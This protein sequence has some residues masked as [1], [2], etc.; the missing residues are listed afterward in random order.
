MLRS[1]PQIDCYSN[2]FCAVDDRG[3]YKDHPLYMEILN[4]STIGTFNVPVVHCTYLINSKYIDKLDY[5]DGSNDYEFVIFSRSA[6]KNNIGQFICNEEKF[7]VLVHFGEETSLQEEKEALHRLP[8]FQNVTTFL[9][10]W[11]NKNY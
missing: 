8:S 2:Y 10:D 9:D 6:R 11:V 5:S 7:G 4:R 1:I 3:Y